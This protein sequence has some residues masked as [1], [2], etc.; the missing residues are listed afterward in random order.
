MKAAASILDAAASASEAEVADLLEASDNV[1][2]LSYIRSVAHGLDEHRDRFI[3]DLAQ[4]LRLTA[5]GL[6][7]ALDQAGD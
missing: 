4:S 2:L 6:I 7:D 1:Y 5:D 3:D